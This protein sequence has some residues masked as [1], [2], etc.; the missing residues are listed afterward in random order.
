MC[1]TCLGKPLKDE[2]GKTVLNAFIE[3]VNK[4][5]LKPEILWIDQGR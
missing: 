1:Q 4:S 5:K 3:T 2:K